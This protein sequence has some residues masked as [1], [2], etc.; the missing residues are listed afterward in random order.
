MGLDCTL[1]DML[2]KAQKAFNDKLPFVIYRNSESNLVK[3]IFQRNNSLYYAKDYRES[4][5]VFAPF[6]AQKE[7]ILLRCDAHLKAERREAM[8]SQNERVSLK[9]DESQKKFH[10]DLVEKGIAE[11]RKGKFQK[12]VLSRKVEADCT[13]SPIDLFQRLLGN[14]ENAFC[15]LWHHPKVG[16]WLGA[17]PEILLKSEN[18]RITTMS[19][20][21]T[22]KYSG[23]DNPTWGTKELEE[24]KLVT[25]Y[26]AGAL[27][28]KVVNL[29]ISERETVKAGSLLHLRTKLMAKYGKGQLGEIVG[30]LHPTPAVCG[31]PMGSSKEFILKNENYE[32]EYYTGYLG[33]LN[34]K[35]ETARSSRRKNQ[36]NQAYKSIKKATTFFVNLRCMQLKNQQAIVYVG[37]GITESSDAEN[38]WAETVSKS[39]VI[40]SIL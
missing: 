17:T 38:E 31:M 6:D 25:K 18:Q 21:G 28:D 11:I 40:K 20:A 7:I 16:T 39:L 30:A 24:Q 1:D 13:A 35:V 12:V 29:K 32:R 33:E 15:Y 9:L 3:G 26:I 37:G 23:N 2:E 36:E 34:L 5:F 4:G 19:L 14:Y 8:I 10:I 27:K 22:Q